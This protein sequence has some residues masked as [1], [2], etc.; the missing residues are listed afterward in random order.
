MLRSSTGSSRAEAEELRR[1]GEAKQGIAELVGDTGRDGGGGFQLLAV[2][3]PPE[4]PRMLDRRGSVI[5]NCGELTLGPR[6]DG[7]GI[8]IVGE[9]DHGADEA[10]RR[11]HR[12][13]EL[14]PAW[15][16]VHEYASSRHRLEPVAP[17]A[18]LECLSLAVVSHGV[19]NAEPRRAFVGNGER[20]RLGA[21]RLAD[22]ARELLCQPLQLELEDAHGSF[23]SP[24]W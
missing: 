16:A 19:C 17:H 8:D 5:G 3:N 10:G 9:H 14:L 20:D 2:L 7:A 13:G 15:C 22:A 4:L 21:H 23:G 24:S 11:E 6:E 1:G 12:C 18:V